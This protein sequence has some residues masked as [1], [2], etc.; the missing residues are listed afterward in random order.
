MK[1]R[2]GVFFLFLILSLSAFAQKNEK[3]NAEITAM[4][5]ELSAKRI[6]S[7][8]RKLVSFGTR[9]TNSAQDNPTRGIGAARDWIFADF[10]KISADCAG[11][12]TVEKQT[13]LQEAMP[14]PRGRVPEAINITNVLAT[15]KGTTDPN[16]TYVISGHYDSMCEDSRD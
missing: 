9:N 6:E 2:Y 12:L 4:L 11:C 14:P 5:K 13:Y 1:F 3:P 16:R 10:Q 7:D 8:I 15:L